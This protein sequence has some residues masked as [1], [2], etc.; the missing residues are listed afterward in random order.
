MGQFHARSNSREQPRPAGHRC[1]MSS[2]LHWRL[3]KTPAPMP[4]RN[5][6]RRRSRHLNIKSI[7][8]ST[9]D[10]SFKARPGVSLRAWRANHPN[11]AARAA[12]CERTTAATAKPGSERSKTAAKRRLPRPAHATIRGLGRLNFLSSRAGT[13]CLPERLP[14]CLDAADS[15]TIPCGLAPIAAIDAP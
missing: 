9:G 13:K 1:G 7:S 5:G 15:L 12:H 11:H 3:A 2:T 8:A 14:K 10:E 4:I 6:I